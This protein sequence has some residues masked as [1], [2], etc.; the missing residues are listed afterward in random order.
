MYRQLP[1]I[2]PYPMP[3]P[4]QLP[5]NIAS[6]E[7]EPHRAALLIHDMQ[8]YFLTSYPAGRPPLT[9]MLA[10]TLVLRTVSDRTGIPVVYTAQP[11]GTPAEQRG[12]LTDF[13][14]P[15]VP[16]GGEHHAIHHDLAPRPG[17]TV[18]TKLRYSAFHRTPL[19]DLLR[20]LGRDQILLCGVYTHIG[21]LHTALDAFAHTVQPFLVADATADFTQRFHT[22]AL[23][24]AAGC[25]AV[26][27]TTDRI[28][29]RLPHLPA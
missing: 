7:P 3:G 26:V 28:R 14:G 19:L 6:W 21:I 27:T 11:G 16:A 23:E 25:C 12:L 1:V 15:G 24:H 9:D 5:V 2:T 10:N 4:H 22:D 13:W 20:A 8:R 29:A 17:D 18:I